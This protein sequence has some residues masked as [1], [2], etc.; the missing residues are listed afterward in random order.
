MSGG[1]GKRHLM[2]A[3][4]PLDLP[5]VHDLRPGPALGRVEH[6]HR[7]A[8]A[9]RTLPRAGGL[10]DLPDLLDGGIKRGGHRL[11]HQRGFVPLDEIGRPAIAAQQLLQLLA[12]DAGE[13]RRVG[14][15]VAVEMQDRQ[16]RAVGRR[17]EELVGMP[18]GGQRPG[19]RL[20]IADDAGDDQVGIVE[21]RAECVAERIAEFAAL[22]D[23]AGAFGRGVARNAAGER[24]LQEQLLQARLVL[25]DM[26]DRPR[27]RCLRDRCSRPPPGHHAQGRRCRSCRG[28]ICVM[29]RF[30]WT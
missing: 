23:R 19:L 2:R 14:D 5:P 3:E 12:R 26:R 13:D 7:P 15:L 21:R 27:C 29:T 22:V 28:R 20:A 10:L 1:V 25:A 30:R 16:H 11:V 24:E 4:R 6:D 8:R 9:L 17:I 18:R